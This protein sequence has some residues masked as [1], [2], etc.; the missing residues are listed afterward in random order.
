MLQKVPA[1]TLTT[2]IFQEWVCTGLQEQVCQVCMISQH[3]FVKCSASAILADMMHL[4]TSS[5]QLQISVVICI[6]CSK[7]TMH[8][9]LMSQW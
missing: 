1:V 3:S 2:A 4:S 9:R 8:W 7:R 5:Q 6:H